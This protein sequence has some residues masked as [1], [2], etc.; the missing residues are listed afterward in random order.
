M[1]AMTERKQRRNRW[2]CRKVREL[3]RQGYSMKE[4]CWK[5]GECT[6]L[7]DKMIEKI[8]YDYLKETRESKAE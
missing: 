2:I 6:G 5:M 1:G 4:A 8:Y 7:S 3:I